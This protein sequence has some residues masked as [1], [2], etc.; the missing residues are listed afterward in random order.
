MS[1]KDSSDN[2]THDIPAFSAMS[3]TAAPPIPP[4]I[5]IDFTSI[6]FILSAN[7]TACNETNFMRL[8]IFIVYC[9]QVRYE[10][11]VSALSLL[12]SMT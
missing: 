9:L 10:L 4:V 8:C 2:R 6:F 11:I 12:A 5:N 3:Q 1:K 7:K